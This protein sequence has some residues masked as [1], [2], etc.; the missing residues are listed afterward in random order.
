[1]KRSTAAAL[2][3]IMATVALTGC[4]A[5]QTPSLI[6]SETSDQSASN[7]VTESVT[8]SVA[9]TPSTVDTTSSE[10]VESDASSAT[11]TASV[12][13][14]E[15]DP[16]TDSD[17][18]APSAQTDKPALT[19]VATLTTLA[20]PETKP[21]EQWPELPDNYTF[22]HEVGAK[23]RNADSFE[24]HETM[25]GIADGSMYESAP[26]RLS[27][28]A[29]G[30][31]EHEYILAVSGNNVY[32]NS[33][34]TDIGAGT[35]TDIY[36]GYKTINGDKIET[37]YRKDNKWISDSSEQTDSTM[38]NAVLDSYGLLRFLASDYIFGDDGA[39]GWTDNDLH[40]CE[41][42]RQ[43]NGDIV[44]TLP[45]YTK[46]LC[47]LFDNEICVNATG[48]M[49]NPNKNEALSMDYGDH[50]KLPIQYTSDLTYTF[51]KDYNI[52]SIS[53]TW[54]TSSNRTDTT[55]HS[56]INVLLEFSNFNNLAPITV[57][58]YEIVE[59]EA[60]T[61]G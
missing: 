52:K 17:S 9:T 6:D 5:S 61:E 43:E 22:F 30:K 42:V 57:P 31:F 24:I 39:Y 37:I 51:D 21:V 8:E 55:K 20:E 38:T 10:P 23:I 1:M 28:V 34:F 29:Q 32:V 15:S 12:A 36:E 2:A 3:A 35:D 7:S 14:T 26:I 11:D 48:L 44:I 56:H 50:E 16:E 27:D 47:N 45:D 18:P 46:T 53:F 54:F 19:T 4:G 25:T 49:Q 33:T 58:D 40:V 41:L 59:P 13:T 60:T